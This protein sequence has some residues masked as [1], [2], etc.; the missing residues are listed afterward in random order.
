MFKNL[1]ATA[2]VL[3]CLI[4]NQLPASA[5]STM[6]YCVYAPHDHTLDAL[7]GPC[8]FSQYGTF[9]GA[10]MYITLPNGVEVAYD[11]RRQGIDFQRNATR[12]RIS[13]TREGVDTLNVFWQKPAHEPGGW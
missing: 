2:C 9:N 8:R 11:G 3:T 7:K 5:D 10:T 6:A 13:I 1:F 4:G 12:E